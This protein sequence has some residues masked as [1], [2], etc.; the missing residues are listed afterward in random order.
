M[1]DSDVLAYIIL[2]RLF[3]SGEEKDQQD[4]L[5]KAAEALLALSPSSGSLQRQL[6][7]HLGIDTIGL[8]TTSVGEVSYSLITVGKYLS[9]NLYVAFGRSLFISH[10]YMLARYNFLK[11]WHI[12]SK[13][14]L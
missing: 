3:K 5:L 7:D 10:N 14:G 13:M 6:R 9:P 1:S 4:L 8:E 12:E 11:N 2:G